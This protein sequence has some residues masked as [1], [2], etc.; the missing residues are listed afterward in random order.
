MDSSTESEKPTVAPGWDFEPGRDSEP[1]L[2]PKVP[3]RAPEPSV[4]DAP[5]PPEDKKPDRR[6]TLLLSAAGAAVA[7]IAIFSAMPGDGGSATPGK[8]ESSASQGDF[9][10]PAGGGAEEGKGD[11]PPKQ[12]GASQAPVPKVVTLTVTPS[13]KGAT[14][15]IVDV[16][17]HNGTDS[18][19]TVMPSL[20]KGDGRPAM[21]GE[22]TLAP[23][24][25][26]IEPGGTGRGTVEFATSE[27][28]AQV[29][30]VDLSGNVVA[31]S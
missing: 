22:G 29:I 14:G 6:K 3:A 23:G 30:L 7:G 27:P 19:L 15:A 4:A 24:L 13:G 16:T 18:A 31:A 20:V 10:P 9:L 25:L 28:P 17:I 12:E 11:Q 2:A 5:G 8:V 21:V 1:N 26:K